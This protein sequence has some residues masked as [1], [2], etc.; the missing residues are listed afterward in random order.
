MYSRLHALSIHSKI[1]IPFRV[2]PA[3]IVLNIQ[4]LFIILQNAKESRL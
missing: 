2:G 4:K 1:N 3:D